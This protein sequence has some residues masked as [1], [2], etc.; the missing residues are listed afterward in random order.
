MQ[1]IESFFLLTP[2]PTDHSNQGS[3]DDKSSV[4]PPRTSASADIQQNPM[5]ATQG[6]QTQ[7]VSRPQV[8][9]PSRPM[10]TGTS[11]TQLLNPEDELDD[12][13]LLGLG[14]DFNILEYADPELDNVLSGNCDKSNILDEQL[15]L[16]EKKD[17]QNKAKIKIEQAG[18]SGTTTTAGESPDLRPK[19]A[20]RNDLVDPPKIKMETNTPFDVNVPADGQSCEAKTNQTSNENPGAKPASSDSFGGPSGTANREINPSLPPP[21][22]YQPPGGIQSAPKDVMPQ[23]KVGVVLHNQPLLLE[24]LLE[25][26]KKEQRQNQNISGLIQ[27]EPLLSDH[28]FEKLKADVLGSNPAQM[29]ISV[30]D[31]S[32]MTQH[33]N[34]RM[35][36]NARLRG[37]PPQMMAPRRFQPPNNLIAAPMPDWQAQQQMRFQNPALRGMSMPSIRMP[38]APQMQSPT[39]GPPSKPPN[40]SPMMHAGLSRMPDHPGPG[41]APMKSP[42]E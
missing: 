23:Q 40:I 20:E 31:A 33:M 17:T 4:P 10:L 34:P 1:S 9:G 28:D 3:A 27:E 16:G 39:H 5:M 21:P 13:E 15:Y 38:G 35:V 22:P 42:G 26:E 14:N 19:S 6:L 7:Q 37:P 41:P 30:S 8:A 2:T 29:N 12:D 24:D 25:Q 18:A 11:E 32:L 36:I